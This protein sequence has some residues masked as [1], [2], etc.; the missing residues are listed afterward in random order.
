MSAKILLT[1]FEPFGGE[2]ENASMVAVNGVDLDGVSTA[3]LPVVFGDAYLRVKELLSERPQVGWVV[4]V[5]QARG[6]SR[7]GLEKVAVN[8]RHSPT[9]AD[10]RGQ[11]YRDAQVVPGG[12]AAYMGPEFLSGLVEQLRGDQWPVELSLSAGSFVCNDLFYLLQHHQR[13]LGV[14][15]LFVHVPAMEDLDVSV[16]QQLLRRVCL[17]L[18]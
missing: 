2:T 11:L 13:E 8:Y 16:T 3:I 10:N 14:P 5:G 4:S 7:V 12:P 1:G 17:A 6:R 9:M 18:D 15:S